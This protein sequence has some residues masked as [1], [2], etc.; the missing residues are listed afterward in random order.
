MD[1]KKE[2]HGFPKGSLLTATFAT[3]ELQDF[4]HNW[5]THARAVNLPN[6]FVIAL[7]AKVAEWCT[8]RGVRSMD[9]SH[10]IDKGQFQAS[11]KGFREH[12][13][14]FNAI[15]EAKILALRGLMDA[16]LDVLLSDVDVVWQGN[17]LQYLSSGQLALADVAVTSDCIFTFEPERPAITEIGQR[18]QPM[19]AD[20][21]TGVLLIRATTAGIDF[22]ARWYK[23]M[24]ARDEITMN[25]QKAFQVVINKLKYGGLIP[26]DGF[27]IGGGGGGG[28]SVSVPIKTDKEAFPEEW[29]KGLRPRYF[30]TMR[31]NLGIGVGD[32]TSEVDVKATAADSTLRVALLPTTT[33]PNGHAQF[34]AQI[35][36]GDV[37]LQPFIYSFIHPFTRFLSPVTRLFICLSTN[38]NVRKYHEYT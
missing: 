30:E 24:N 28:V 34:V 21:N 26:V 31:R 15:G 23:L 14:S 33:F 37:S 7:D 27:K 13:Q 6:V 1:D 32:G 22:V 16:G 12:K 35:P 9:A 5:L 20:F 11:V 18:P 17:P 38:N 25:D 19:N 3:A 4:L 2:R 36:V 10:L 8:S 29:R